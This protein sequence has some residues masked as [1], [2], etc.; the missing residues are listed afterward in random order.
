MS[1]EK[2]L[3]RLH[4]KVCVTSKCMFNASRRFA[5]HNRWSRST[6]VMFSLCL[7]LIPLL[8]AFD[9]RSLYPQKVVRMFQIYYAIIILVYSI[10]IALQDFS[11]V[12]EKLHSC[13]QELLELDQRI[14]PFACAE[15]NLRKYDEFLFEYM[16]I[17]KKY[18][19]HHN[20]LDFYC[21][22]FE[23]PEYYKPRW[24]NAIVIFLLCIINFFHYF[25]VL[26]IGAI[27]IYYGFSFGDLFYAT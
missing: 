6:I 23:L 18:P 7:I 19:V 24:A 15:I 9:I 14:S 4:K 12:S 22:R 10:V 27:F 20:K 25:V 21:S 13:G 2:S 3:K 1:I 16:N 11:L 17:L 26:F 5:L 8:Q